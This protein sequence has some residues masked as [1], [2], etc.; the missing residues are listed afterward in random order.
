MWEELSV[1]YCYYYNQIIKVQY[2]IDVIINVS[3]HKRN[4]Y[5]VMKK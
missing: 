5:F 2:V 4:V 1:G 3:I